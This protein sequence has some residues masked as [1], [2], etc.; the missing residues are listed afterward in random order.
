MSGSKPVAP[1]HTRFAA[2]H[3]WWLMLVL[4]LGASTAS[5]L[6]SSKALTQYVMT[7]WQ[8]EQGLPQNTVTS[9]EIG[10]AHV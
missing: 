6:D 3:P 9:V 4:W 5:A 2:G 1:D 10:R 8:A 7:T